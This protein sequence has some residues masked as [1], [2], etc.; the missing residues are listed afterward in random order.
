M[1]CSRKL[2]KGNSYEICLPLVDSGVTM[3]RFYTTGSV[4]VE[5]E[6]EIVDD[7]MCFTF[8]EEELAVLPD[9]VLRMEV[10]T[11]YETIDTNTPYVISTPGDYS[12]TTLDEMLDDAYQSGYTEG[13]E[14]CTGGTCEWAYESGYTSGYESGSTDGYDSGYTDGQAAC[15]CTDA[16]NSGYTDGY[17]SGY[18]DGYNAEHDYEKDYFTIRPR[19][20]RA[21]SVNQYYLDADGYFEYRFNTDTPGLWR[22]VPTSG[23]AISCST[24]QTISFRGSGIRQTNLFSG[25]TV[26]FDVEGNIESLEYGDDFYGKKVCVTHCFGRLFI[27]SP[28][29]RRT[30]NLVLPATSVTDYAYDSMFKNCTNLERPV[31]LPATELST[32]CYFSMF[33]GCTKLLYAPTLPATYIRSSAY[34]CMFKDCVMLETTPVMSATTLDGG[35]GHFE[36]MFQ[37]CTGITHALL[38]PVTE[39]GSYSYSGMFSGC[40]ALNY[41]VCEV[42]SLGQNSTYNWMDGVAQTGTFIKNPNM[43]SWSSGVDGIPIGWTVQDAT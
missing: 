14:D 36:N 19:S 38:P 21:F 11:E 7:H 6:P 20:E 8:T 43:N 29:L 23:I 16:Y 2:F 42:T 1:Y 40:T 37:G 18:T 32:G 13:Q 5:K 30:D 27:D 39:L 12:G 10:V 34:G 9:G 22:E 24:G 41:V 25:N 4:I 3:V 33:A 15:D 28:G 26:P 31:E 35:V 17:Q